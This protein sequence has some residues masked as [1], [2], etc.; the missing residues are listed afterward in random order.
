MHQLVEFLASINSKVLPYPIYE[1]V[2][3]I[4]FGI[5][6]S[7]D[8]HVWKNMQVSGLL[9]IVVLSGAN[10]VLL[11][12]FFDKLLYFIKRKPR[13][14][15]ILICI[16]L[17]VYLCGASPSLVRAMIMGIIAQ[18]S[19]LIGRRTY[20][21]VSLILAFII[22]WILNP[23]NIS[24]LS[25]ILSFSACLGIVLFKEDIEKV[26]DRTWL[27]AIKSEISLSIAAQV[28]VIPIIFWF[29]STIS[30][31]STLSTLL[32]FPVVV[33]LMILAWVLPIIH[34]VSPDV[35]MLLTWVTYYLGQW[36]YL[37]ATFIGESKFLYLEI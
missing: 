25:F 5:N 8:G 9:H 31:A 12:A 14:I 1:I 10:I 33:P 15:L 21:A 11:V 28:L 16:M 20:S 29:F 19:I 36:V 17:Y 2:N 6:L 27:Q 26:L 37:V 4:G 23:S 22:M 35:S 3:G 13:S 24:D 32:V 30:L 34:L 18:F 7:R